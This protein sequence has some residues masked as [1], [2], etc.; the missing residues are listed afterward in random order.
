MQEEPSVE[1][2]SSEQAVRAYQFSTH[3][4][5]AFKL[6]PRAA[7]ACS[8]EGMGGQ[9][10]VAYG[11][12][13]TMQFWDPITQL[14]DL[15]LGKSELRMDYPE[16]VAQLSPSLLAVVPG[17]R[18]NNE[19]GGRRG[20]DDVAA[21]SVTFVNKRMSSQQ[22]FL[23]MEPVQPWAES[24]H[25]G[26]IS[27]V[28]GMLG[29]S[30]QC[31]E[32]ALMLSGGA[33]DKKVYLWSVDLIGGRVAKA[34]HTQQMRAF[35]TSR[36]TALRYEPSRGYVI[37][38]AES[39]RISIN[40]VETGKLVMDTAK[41][42]VRSV[43]GSLVASPVN[44]NIIMASCASTSDQL[45]LFDLRQRDMSIRPALV[46]GNETAR[47][48]SRYIRPAWHPDGCLVVCPVH[49]S[50]Q[51]SSEA[52]ASDGMVAI[53]DTRYARCDG[54]AP[55]TYH[56]HKAPVWSAEFVEPKLPGLS[57]MVTTGGDHNIGFTSFRA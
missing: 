14:L 13:G 5:H 11:M 2:Q 33:K 31:S 32:R 55:Q 4:V 56:P 7:F 29:C 51:S 15:S 3:S 17:T 9:T 12:D 35:H 46:L 54:E 50:S 42:T 27:V 45:K 37:S 34:V 25:E 49:R 6:K 53:W 38:G 52:A 36:V 41:N 47:T 20:N 40:D 30:R 10:V 24:P 19:S 28:E 43:I 21:A 1:L 26:P 57:M 23:Q 48:Q 18:S 44:C 16:H 22:G 8:L 39:G